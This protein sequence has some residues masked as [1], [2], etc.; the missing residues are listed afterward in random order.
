MLPKHKP[1]DVKDATID[2]QVNPDEKDQSVIQ[3]MPLLTGSVN[4]LY[5]EARLA[6]E[7]NDFNLALEKLTLAYEIQQAPQISQLMAEIELHKGDFSQAYHWA[8]ISIEN[9]PDKGGACEK[10][11]RI[12]AVASEKL[13]NQK[14]RS[15]ALQK[16]HDCRVEARVEY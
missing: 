9:G 8:E 15:K 5:N 11:W 14:A 10:S 6:F 12:L 1:A 16:K 13:G 3:T 4:N 2:R 7:N